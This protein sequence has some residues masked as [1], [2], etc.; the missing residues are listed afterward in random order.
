MG[1]VLS[2]GGLQGDFTNVDAM[3]ALGEKWGA[4]VDKAIID[5]MCGPLT[6]DQVRERLGFMPFDEY[7][8]KIRAEYYPAIRKNMPEDAY[9]EIVEEGR[10]TG[11]TTRAICEAIAAA[12]AGKTVTIVGGADAHARRTLRDAARGHAERCGVDP[13]LISIAGDSSVPYPVEAVVLDRSWETPD[14][15]HQFANEI[16]PALSA[17][18]G[19]D[20]AELSTHRPTDR[21][22]GIRR[23]SRNLAQQ[24]LQ[25]CGVVGKDGRIVSAEWDRFGDWIDFLVEDPSYEPMPEGVIPPVLNLHED[26]AEASERARAGCEAMAAANRHHVILRTRCGAEREMAYPSAGGYAIEVPLYTD[27]RS[28]AF[29]VE[30]MEIIPVE[31]RTF[32]WE[33]ETRLGKRV[34]VEQPEPATERA[35]VARLSANVARLADELREAKGEIEDLRRER[36]QAREATEA[37]TESRYN[38]WMEYDA[39]RTARDAALAERDAARAAVERL[40]A[41]ITALEAGAVMIGRTAGPVEGPVEAGQ[42]IYLY[43]GSSARPPSLEVKFEREQEDYSP[44]S[45]PAAPRCA[46]FDQAGRALGY[47]TPDACDGTVRHYQSFAADLCPKH[48]RRR[49]EAKSPSRS[50]RW[51]ARGAAAAG[52]MAGAA[53]AA[54]MVLL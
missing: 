51:L 1:E 32:R 42:P 52:A 48:A 18:V 23:V 25:G 13:S 21:R 7:A 30:H 29:G 28:I 46:D 14:R 39:A 5:A 12:S 16:I 31:S 53:G 19:Q 44:T 4:A 10:R 24:I 2:S 34:F 45:A 27:L 54:W 11:R 22:V 20:Q 41:Q 8:A 35:N 9:R 6:V 40:K 17:A 26:R 36:D 50:R 47:V 37:M 43:R 49:M 38:A 33:G 3:R 15:E